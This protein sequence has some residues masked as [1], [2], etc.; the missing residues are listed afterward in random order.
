MEIKFLI[1]KFSHTKV[2]FELIDT[3]ESMWM[4]CFMISN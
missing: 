3:F 1:H 2:P 4:V